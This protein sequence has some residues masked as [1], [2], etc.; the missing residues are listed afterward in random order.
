MRFSKSSQPASESIS[1]LF[2]ER[3]LA[4]KPKIDKNELES[5][6]WVPYTSNI[7]ECRSSQVRHA[8]PDYRKSMLSHHLEN[9]I[10]WTVKRDFWKTH[11]VP[12]I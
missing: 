8:F 11:S 4:K 6:G 5:L 2:A 1:L 7:V 10:F 12:V 3:V 9:Q